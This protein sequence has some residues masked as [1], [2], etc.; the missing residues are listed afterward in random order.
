VDPFPLSA[1][2]FLKL[3][4]IDPTRQR[5]DMIM[6]LVF[7]LAHALLAGVL[8]KLKT[9]RGLPSRGCCAS[10]S[11][12]STFS[13]SASVH[14]ADSAPSFAPAGASDARHG[15]STNGPENGNGEVKVMELA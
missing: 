10:S 9:R 14:A 2:L 7:A 4:G 1:N 5:L 13:R 11:S 12:E 3:L 6:L 8:L 15:E